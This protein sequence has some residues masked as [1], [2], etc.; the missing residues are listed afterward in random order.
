MTHPSRVLFLHREKGQKL[1]LPL[2]AGGGQEEALS[3]CS[4]RLLHCQCHDRECW[5]LLHKAQAARREGGWA[6]GRR[7]SSSE[8]RLCQQRSQG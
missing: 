3:E 2:E 6:L 1:R 5:E 4:D 7:G 8:W